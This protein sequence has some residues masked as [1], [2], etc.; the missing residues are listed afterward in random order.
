LAPTQEDIHLAERVECALRR[1][2][3]G[4]FWNID[5]TVHMP[6]VILRGRVPTYYLKQVAQATALSVPG[7]DQVGN[8]LE[9]VTAR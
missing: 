1:A 5:V 6:L 4:A 7:V 9:V 8:D 3:Y 2:G